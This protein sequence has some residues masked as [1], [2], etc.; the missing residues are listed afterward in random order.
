MNFNS[1]IH[2]ILFAFFP[3]LFLFSNNV[4]QLK[5]ND[6]IFSSIIIISIT[7][8]VWL[9]IGRISKNYIKSSL[10]ISIFLILFFS[11]GRIYSI[12]QDYVITTNLPAIGHAIPLF[13]FL[14][15]FVIIT[16][17][18]IKTKKKFNNLTKIINSVAVVIV[19]ISL[20]NV[21][22]FYLINSSNPQDQIFSDANSLNSKISYPNIYFIILDE[23]A[24]SKSLEKFYNFDNTYFINSLEERGFYFPE[25]PTAN[26]PTTTQSMTSM[27]NMEYVDKNLITDSGP[28]N[29][30]LF[31]REITNNN[32][33]QFLKNKGYTIFNY[34]SG[35]I[36]TQNIEI[37]DY[38][39]CS[40][41][42][43]IDSQLLVNLLETSMLNPVYV[44][45]F[46]DND[47]EQRLCILSTLGEPLKTNDPYFV[48]AHINIPHPPYLFGPNG[49]F[50]IPETLDLEGRR[51]SGRNIDGY[52]GQLQFVNN[53]ILNIVDKIHENEQ[54]LAIIVILSDHGSRYSVHWDKIYEDGVAPKESV[55][56]RLSILNTIYFPDKNYDLI[57]DN[58]SSVNMFRIILNEYVDGDFEILEDK[59]YFIVGREPIVFKDVT[60]FFE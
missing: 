56:E 43:L 20:F 11:Y 23:Y 26:Y 3:I 28:Q 39:L 37:A 14:T 7:L 51:D 45:F 29:Y 57:Y 31:L 24:H 44:S 36:L 22:S 16:V 41:D 52:I 8:V 2:P 4:S 19:L 12:L 27:L 53:Q 13:S 1:A 21:T 55:Q 46:A 5:I 33:M 40:T 15:L 18:I 48:F 49:E 25:N 47:R 42:I 54:K 35:S 30:Q 6:L 10:V 34:F 60:E 17:L 58:I 9:I 59:N 32:L 38:H 50:L